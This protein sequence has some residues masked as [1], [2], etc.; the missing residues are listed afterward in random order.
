MEPAAAE[1][2]RQARDFERPGAAADARARLEHD[3]GEPAAREPPRRA[4]PRGSGSD[5]GDVE[6]SAHAREHSGGQRPRRYRL[7]WM[8]LRTTG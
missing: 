1:I 3:G 8:W 2:E 5:N 7:N 6:I 4:D